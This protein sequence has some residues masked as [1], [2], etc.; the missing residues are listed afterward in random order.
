MS[1]L[2]TI[3][4]LIR[5]NLDPTVPRSALE[6]QLKQIDKRRSELEERIA[7]LPD[8]YEANELK[9]ERALLGDLRRDIDFQ[10]RPATP[11]A[12]DPAL[13]KQMA[14]DRR[15]DI[16]LLKITISQRTEQTIAQADRCAETGDH[17]QAKIWRLTIPEIPLQICKEYNLDPALL[18][19]VVRESRVAKIQVARRR[20]RAKA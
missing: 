13:L 5:N 3:P 19:D 16:N 9:S 12:P 7:R 6:A 20:A 4:N 8:S 1:D 11:T 2:R 15:R 17:R 10:L 18:D 14:E